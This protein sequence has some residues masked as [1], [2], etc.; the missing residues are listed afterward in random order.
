MNIFG[1]DTMIK[2]NDDTNKDDEHGFYE[3][4]KG[5]ISYPNRELNIADNMNN[6]SSVNKISDN[7]LSHIH[8][9]G[10]YEIPN[11]R[12]FFNENYRGNM[13]EKLY[14]QRN[15]I[16]M[17]FSEQEMD[18]E[19]NYDDISSS[20]DYDLND[21]NGY[22]SLTEGYK[23][24]YIMESLFDKNSFVYFMVPFNKYSYTNYYNNWNKI[25]FRM[26]ASLNSVVTDKIIK[27]KRRGTKQ[28]LFLK[29][30]NGY[31]IGN[32][33]DAG[34]EDENFK[35]PLISIMNNF[36]Y[37]LLLSEF[38][39]FNELFK[40]MPLCKTSYEIFNKYFSINVH[41]N[42]FKQNISDIINF[43][44]LN[45]E[46]QFNILQR[47]KS[48][49]QE[50]VCENKR[51][52]LSTSKN[53]IY[54]IENKDEIS[55]EGKFPNTNIMKK[56]DNINN[57][58]NTILN[59]LSGDKFEVRNTNNEINNEENAVLKKKIFITNNSISMRYLFSLYEF[60]R[61]YLSKYNRGKLYYSISDEKFKYDSKKEN[62][63][64]RDI[65]PYG[66]KICS[67][68]YKV[69]LNK[70]IQR[71]WNLK[72]N[73]VHENYFCHKSNFQKNLGV[74]KLVHNRESK[75]YPSGTSFLSVDKS[76]YINTWQV[77][78]TNSL[79]PMF[80]NQAQLTLKNNT[81]VSAT[82]VVNLGGDKFL[83]SDFSSIYSFSLD[84]IDNG[85][86]N[87]VKLIDIELM[88][89]HKN[90]NIKNIIMC[91]KNKCCAGLSKAICHRID[92]EMNKIESSKYLMENLQKINN[93]D[94]NTNI[95]LTPKNILIDDKRLANYVPYVNY[96]LI[97][98]EN[99]K[100]YY[101]SDNYFVDIN[102]TGISLTSLNSSNSIY[103]FDLRYKYP[104]TCLYYEPIITETYRLKEND[105]L[106]Y[107][108][109]LKLNYNSRHYLR[110]KK[111]SGLHDNIILYPSVGDSSQ[112]NTVC[113]Q[114][115]DNTT[116]IGHIDNVQYVKNKIFSDE[117]FIYTI[118]KEIKKKEL[119]NFPSSY[120]NMWRWCDKRQFKSFFHY[121][122]DLINKRDD[123]NSICA[124]SSYYQKMTFDSVYK[125]ID[126]INH[127]FVTYENSNYIHSLVSPTYGLDI[128]SS[129]K[130]VPL[131][132][133]PTNL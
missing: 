3:E 70:Y 33:N 14:S 130:E 114:N 16:G 59:N 73:Y 72:G 38:L 10:N 107:L 31:N 106:K 89:N 97:D 25:S 7:Y 46:Y 60:M 39:N 69:K 113:E 99:D 8:G 58:E 56:N 98:Y 54:D 62:S 85:D 47:R 117:S 80:L 48:K 76:G 103:L 4:T 2:K 120:L 20:I 66:N 121:H 75:I 61:V 43:L 90:E 84:K 12:N 108:N 17:G 79:L 68:E 71:R 35:N 111:Y 5:S 52:I 44:K 67:Y 34:I 128:K 110:L 42:P 74:L 23:T 101:N 94:N 123:G 64:F 124:P 81:N 30:V 109:K 32:D 129:L 26:Y 122:E 116:N 115:P 104:S 24:N 119:D 86:I 1:K 40:L 11:N 15:R 57:N 53:S 77:N 49:C 112:D 132:I 6:K 19:D 102:L 96:N 133:H 65:Y 93:F 29:N 92:L 63:F 100:K 50:Y 27:K 45:K 37:F 125:F 28:N 41:I 118:V 22:Y 88:G 36:L 82:D 126:S 87:L 51:E 18:D 78:H 55:V 83:L 131:C 105:K 91:E 9:K 21:D 13:M 127:L 95:V